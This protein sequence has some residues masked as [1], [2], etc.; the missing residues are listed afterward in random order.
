MPATSSLERFEPRLAGKESVK[1]AVFLS[2]VHGGGYTD[3]AENEEKTKDVAGEVAA[4]SLFNE[5]A[6]ACTARPAMAQGRAG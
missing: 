1:A 2:T 3:N 6:T 4:V 5:S